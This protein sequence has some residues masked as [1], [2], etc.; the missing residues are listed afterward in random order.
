MS[1]HCLIWFCNDVYAKYMQFLYTLPTNG[2]IKFEIYVR[3]LAKYSHIYGFP[4]KNDHGMFDLT[5]INEMSIGHFFLACEKHLSQKILAD[6]YTS[7]IIPGDPPISICGFV[8]VSFIK[9]IFDKLCGWSAREDLINDSISIIL[10]G[11]TIATPQFC[12]SNA[13]QINIQSICWSWITLQNFCADTNNLQLRMS[14]SMYPNIVEF[15][16]AWLP[17]MPMITAD[18]FIT[19]NFIDRIHVDQIQARSS[20]ATNSQSIATNTR[21]AISIR[22]RYLNFI[23]ID[24]DA[25][26]KSVIAA[27]F[28]TFQNN[29]DFR[30]RIAVELPTALLMFVRKL[31]EAL[32]NSDKYNPR[33]LYP[34]VFPYYSSTERQAE[35]SAT[36]LR[37]IIKTT[38][39]VDYGK[40][41]EMH[42][43]YRANYSD[44][45]AK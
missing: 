25:D 8:D 33:R 37:D 5:Q 42:D 14:K 38:F 11:T 20:G 26:T 43:Q 21:Y 3:L 22:R 18:E 10:S 40:I 19:L 36:T 24:Y 4:I 30:A 34:V 9:I 16:F 17:Q 7:C 2:A 15:L 32:R 27:E 31:Y 13:R 39:G 12:D 23:I 41:V 35:F 6:A 28:N 44:I 45:G 29:D 1:S